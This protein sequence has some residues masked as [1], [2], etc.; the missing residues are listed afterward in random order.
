MSKKNWLNNVQ[1]WYWPVIINT[2]LL[3][4]GIIINLKADAINEWYYLNSSN[5]GPFI[6]LALIIKLMLVQ[7]V[8]G[9]LALFGPGVR[10]RK[11]SAL[12]CFSAIIA[13]IVFIALLHHARGY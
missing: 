11:L 12:L 10:R 1:L 5:S 7:T 4:V 2:A 8:V 6:V 9:F 3:G 13:E